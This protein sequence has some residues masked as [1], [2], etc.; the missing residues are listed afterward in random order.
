MQNDRIVLDYQRQDDILYVTFGEEG[1]KGFGVN[2]HDNVLLRFDRNSGEPL[3]LTFI[4]YSRL[5]GL[6]AVPLND[7]SKLPEGVEPMVRRILLS[8]PVCRFIEVD[9][10]TFNHF[11]V[12]NPSMEEV[13]AG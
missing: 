10:T 1:R 3:G 12:V 7:F 2:L 4:D 8:E 5:K 6:G 9:T 13:I 11:S